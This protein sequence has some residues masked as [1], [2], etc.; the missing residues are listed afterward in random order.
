[1]DSFLSQTDVYDSTQKRWSLPLSST[2]TELVN[3]V[4]NIL[5]SIVG[6]LVRSETPGVERRV[7]STDATPGCDRSNEEGYRV[8]PILVVQ[9]AG[10]SF[11]IPV[12]VDQH[13]DPQSS[14][15]SLS[16]S[17][18]G[19]T[20]MATYITLK[21][22]SELLNDVDV[23]REMASYAR[24]VN[25]FFRCHPSPDLVR[26]R[27]TLYEQP[28][29]F[30]V[31]SLVL[32][33][34]HARL[35]HIDRAG[36][37][38]TPPIDIHGDP[39]TFVR[40][41]MGISSMN[42]TLLGIDNSI[43]WTIVN[44]RKENGTLTTTGPSGEQKT[45][46]ILEIVPTPRDAVCGRAT[47]CWRVQDPDTHEEYVVKDAWRSGSHAPEHELLGLA[48][49]LP[50]VVHMVSYEMGR[51]EAKDF[52]C[53]TTLGQYHNRIATRTTMKSYGKSIVSFT[54]ILQLLYALRDAIAGTFVYILVLYFRY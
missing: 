18:V 31:R 53:P 20:N 50:G 35:V 10:P 44:G 1:M 39:R 12:P 42:E 25:Q 49:G 28:N 37:Q 46:P 52:R 36:A 9:A 14:E 34:Q 40:I 11:E 33:P 19:F 54:S 6:P 32:T 29:R 22:D 43:R 21:T 23:L 5:Q 45:Y 38:I 4:F 8:S 13:C 15:A 51:G 2:S 48:R 24:Y 16:L 17:A 27:Y 47:T 3:A 41:V 7:Y 26:H 30:Y